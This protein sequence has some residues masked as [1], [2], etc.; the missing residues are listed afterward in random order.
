ML[1]GIA[2]ALTTSIGWTKLPFE[3]GYGSGWTCWRMREWQQ[4]G[5]FDRLHHA[6][7]D[8][9]GETGELDRPRQPG[10]GQRR[11][12]R[13]LL[14]GQN[15]TDRAS[16]A[17]SPPSSIPTG[18]RSPWPSPGPIGTPAARRADPGLDAGI[19]RGGRGQAARRQGL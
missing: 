1:E 15:P 12:K 3:L 11:A 10:L 17:P 9:L 7:L 13:G 16:A 19:H 5:I 4:A 2:F 18:Y 6:L 8:R 14:T